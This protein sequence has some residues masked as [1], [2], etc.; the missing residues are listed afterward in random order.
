MKFAIIGAGWLGCH[1]AY[2]L[3][4]KLHKVHLFDQTG[5]FAGS[6]LFNQN[7][8]HKG[9]HYSRN[10][11]T[12]KLC[13]DTFDLFVNDYPDII[14]EVK[15]NFYV[16]PIDKSLIDYRTF[17]TVFLYEK[18]PFIE[19][20]LSCLT[21]IEGGLI[22]DEKYI[23][24]FKAKNFFIHN[25]QENLHISKISSNNLQ[26]L[27]KDFDFVIN[28]TNNVLE[29]LS[30]CHFELC[31]TLVYDS[32]TN[33]EFDSITVVDGSFFSIFPYHSSKFTVTDV[34]HTPIFRSNVYSD[35]VNYQKNV[36]EKFIYN[37]RTKVEEKIQYYYK[38]FCKDFKY[39]SY[40]TS[41]KVKKLSKSADRNPIITKTDNI[42]SCV[43]GK[44]Q[45]IYELE[46]FINNEITNR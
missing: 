41:V 36:D 46:T 6:S 10:E 29:P 2:K 28:V 24:P 16:V 26:T 3:K 42:I 27:S 8:L 31:L 35:I 43:T 37:I 44:I 18:I 20:K 4:K 13:K 15:N 33:L 21:N 30:E 38:D 32:L 9:F 40:Y 12:R 7:R 5:I 17:K 14:S 39:T 19:S 34:E 11:K 25:L 45:G 1:T 23:D 22:V